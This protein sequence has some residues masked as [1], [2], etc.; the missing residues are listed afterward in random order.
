[1]GI[2]L[3]LLNASGSL[4]NNYDAIMTG[5]NQ[6]IKN[7]NKYLSIDNVDI[8]ISNAPYAAIPELGVGGFCDSRYDEIDISIDNQKKI[9]CEV[10][11]STL[12]H[13]LYHM[14]RQRAYKFPETVGEFIVD[15][16]LACL[17]ECELTKVKPIYVKQRI[18]NVDINIIQEHINDKS[19]IK[20]WLLGNQK[21]PRWL[22]Y[23]VG[24]KIAKKYSKYKKLKA[25]QMIDVN[26]EDFIKYYFAKMK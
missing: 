18:K 20:K 6:A 26:A 14:A 19:N 16:G 24:F 5:Y 25:H 12:Y 9:S 15:E 13:E 1:M 4:D 22:G 2:Q 3:H 23:N 8:V 10:I 21:I 7:I 17:F 11:E